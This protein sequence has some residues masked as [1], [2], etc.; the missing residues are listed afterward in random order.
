MTGEDMEGQN[1]PEAVAAKGAEVNE[2]VEGRLK[3]W[4]NEIIAKKAVTKEYT[5][6]WEKVK[7]GATE[8]SF[9]QHVMEKLTPLVE[10]LAVVRGIRAEQQKWA[11]KSIGLVC[12][13]AG[14]VG[15]LG[16]PEIGLPVGAIGTAAGFASNIVE[17]S[18]KAMAKGMGKAGEIMNKTGLV[19]R[20][21][22]I[23]DKIVGWKGQ[24]KPVQVMY[25]E[26]KPVVPKMA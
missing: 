26:A 2:K 6:A 16:G 1:S 4:K 15:M 21:D 11:L 19:Q 22:R 12:K 23:V 20:V 10:N 13:V 18:D 5:A 7:I 25:A 9:R 17:I 24:E 3:K 8:G 14:L